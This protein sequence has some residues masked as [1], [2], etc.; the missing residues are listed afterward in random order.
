MSKFLNKFKL[1]YFEGTV[2]LYTELR[3]LGD[4]GTDNW[5]M[6][7]RKRQNHAN[8]VVF[9]W[10]QPFQPKPGLVEMVE[11]SN[12][13][14]FQPFLVDTRLWLGMVISKLSFFCQGL[15]DD[16]SATRSI[17]CPSRT[18]RRIGS[19]T[20]WVGRW[21]GYILET[22]RTPATRITGYFENVVPNFLLI[23]QTAS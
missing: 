15:Q 6:K 5:G 1:K 18:V 12:R 7:M 16:G 22:E 13:T 4:L 21:I 8:K 19:T 9:Y 14:L 23:Y 11:V 10:D 17:G 3:I 20:L 2:F